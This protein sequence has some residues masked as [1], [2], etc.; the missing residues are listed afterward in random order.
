[1]VPTYTGILFSHK[2]K[3]SINRCW[4]LDEPGKHYA[5]QNKGDK[6]VHILYGIFYMIFTEQ[7]KA[8]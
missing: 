1:M 2:K 3:Q 7:A 8:D 5:K 4:N 6:K